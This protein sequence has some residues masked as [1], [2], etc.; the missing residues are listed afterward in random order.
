[1]KLIK[2]IAHEKLVIMVTH[3][4]ELATKYASRII[5]FSDGCIVS[6]SH[7]YQVE[8]HQQTDQLRMTKMNYFT[9]LNLSGKNMITKMA[10]WLN[11]FCL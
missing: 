1:M 4:A 6:D 2:E 5:E 7:P 11:G 9:A 10:N 8:Q 3:N